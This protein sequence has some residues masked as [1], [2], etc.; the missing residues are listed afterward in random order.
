MQHLILLRHAKAERAS[1]SG[2]D[3][4][5]PLAERGSDDARLMGRV[6]AEAG[7]KPELALVSPAT[8]TRETWAEATLA[9]GAEI[10][11]R[12][13]KALYNAA[14]TTLRRL[15]ESVEEAPGDVILVGHNPGIHQLAMELLIEGAAAPSTLTRVASRFPTASAVVFAM[16]AAGRPTY[17][18]LYFAADYGGGAGE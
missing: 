6:L 12:Y 9:F 13:D 3:F 15:A 1:A 11:A 7:L 17:D 16:D 2:D 5:R 14:S 18:G 10:E 4:D 8:R